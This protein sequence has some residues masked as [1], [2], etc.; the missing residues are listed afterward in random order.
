MDDTA[1]TA[2]SPRPVN[3][4]AKVKVIPEAVIAERV[5]ADKW[6]PTPPNT[7]RAER[8]RQS[9]T[10]MRI[11]D[12]VAASSGR[13]AG[14]GLDLE[15][16]IARRIRNVPAT[17]RRAVSDRSHRLPPLSAFGGSIRRDALH[18]DGVDRS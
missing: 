18:R 8:D 1:H 15:S 2:E 3:D 12:A 10:W 4:D 13:V 16:A 7:A 9:V 14:R 17:T 6:M 11:S 5:A